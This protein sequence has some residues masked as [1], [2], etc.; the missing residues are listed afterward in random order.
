MTT[1]LPPLSPSPTLPLA[2]TSPPPRSK[3]ALRRSPPEVYQIVVECRDEAD[4]RHL[5]D[6]LARAG[7]TL[8]L[9]VL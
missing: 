6:R 5:F 8:R 4:Q 2:P 3:S 9:L 1:S 7:L